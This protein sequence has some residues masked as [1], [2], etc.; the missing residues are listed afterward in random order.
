M[1]IIIDDFYKNREPRL[2]DK[3][4]P[5]LRTNCGGLKVLKCNEFGR[6]VGGKWENMYDQSRRV[7][8]TDGLSPTIHTM[9]G[10]NTEIKVAIMK[11]TEQVIC[12]RISYDRGFEDTEDIASTLC[13]RDYKGMG[14]FK[15]I[16]A[17]AEPLPLEDEQPKYKIRKLTPKECWRLM[18]FDDD[19]FE[20]AEKVCSNSQLYKQAGNSIVVNVL[21]GILKNLLPTKTRSEWLDEILGGV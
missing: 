18:G 21:E 1:K 13:A 8:A 3:H 10:G 12:G 17:V 7:Y 15:A 19:D 20:K 2:Y 14:R 4:A 11:E 5:T 16:N 6:L 9:G